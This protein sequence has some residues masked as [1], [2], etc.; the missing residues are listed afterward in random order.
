MPEQFADK[1]TCQRGRSRV[2]EDERRRQAQ[3]G[4]GGQPAAQVDRG[5]RVEPELTERPAGLDRVRRRVAKHECRA[6]PDQIDHGAFAAGPRKPGELVPQ[7]RSGDFRLR[8]NG[9]G[10]FT[11]QRA[12]PA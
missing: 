2:V 8:D 5:D 12:R 4:R 9:C 6:G 7:S 1:E 3:P 10:Q 11:E